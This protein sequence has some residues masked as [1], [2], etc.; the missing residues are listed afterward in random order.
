MKTRAVLSLCALLAVSL[1]AL[2]AGQ[3]TVSSPDG[4]VQFQLATSAAG[5]LE[6]SVTFGG[7]AIIETSPIGIVVD[8]VNLAEGAE[9]GDAERY[10]VDEKYP[11]NGVHTPAIDH[12][13][14]A[15]VAVKHVKSGTAYTLEI[16]AYDDGVAF[17]HVVPGEGTRV[18]DE[19]SA[20]K[21]PNGTT[22]WY[23]DLEDHYEGLQA[24][25]SIRAVPPGGF[26]APP[27]TFRLAGNGPYAA[28]TEGALQN[29][30]GMGLQADGNG[31][32][33]ARLGHAI[34]ASYPFRLRFPN[35]VER[36][37]HAAAVTGTITTP[38]RVVMIGA[39]LNTLVNCDIVHN[40]A[41]PPDPKLFP[42]GIHTDWIKPGRAVWAYLDGGND[43]LEG[44][45]EFSRLAGEL[46]FEYN[47]L[48]GFWSRWPEA[49][50]KEL[51]DYSRQRGVRIIIW[52]SR[53]RFK[54]AQDIRDLAELS[55][56][57]GVAGW[58][59]DFFD[60]ENKEVV[61]LYDEILRICAAYHLV[62]DFHGANKPTGME[63]T[64]PN[65]IGVEAI[66]GMEAQP[67][68]A[69]HEVT[70]PFTRMLAGL[71]DYTPM[72]FGRKLADTTWVHQVGNAILLQAP[73]LVFAAHPANILANPMVDVIKQIPSTWD[74]TVV[75]PI[76][77]IG[78]VAA[79]ARRKGDTWFLAVNNGPY[80]K[81][82]RVDLSFLAPA[83][84]VE[85]RRGET[86]I[87]TLLRDTGEAAAV[88]IDHRTVSAGDSLFA[89]LRSG[90]GFVA[91]FTK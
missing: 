87:A 53:A 82:V 47:L 28:I 75:L 89:D 68:Y 40:V 52:S 20:F 88:K 61:D 74:E 9:I 12:C 17:R 29:Y 77:E 32:L 79:F 11:W 18:P 6:Y 80:A 64:Y 35:D 23:H 76:S 36:L 34:P 63:R 3:L 60:H 65:N 72:D 13:N 26:L 56:R 66:R 38:W 33:Y 54:T 90:G 4:R 2:G 16:R 71:A 45:E 50:L 91:M 70:L 59:I 14:G 51:V 49:Q 55:K 42:N 58:K 22:L 5:S 19:A 43:T 31:M 69:L 15:R 46:G 48:E 86:F 41:P 57:T 44:M 78:D 21:L 67:P 73:L 1:P 84:S 85:G 30:S 81:T 7:K 83:G 37:S 62:V 39:D 24:R 25:K 8:K 27:V 10:Q